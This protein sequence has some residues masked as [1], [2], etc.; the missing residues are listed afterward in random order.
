MGKVQP[1]LG[2]KERFELRPGVAGFPQWK[3]QDV[4]SNPGSIPIFKLRQLINGR[5]REDGI[6]S[7]GGQT[8]LNTSALDSSTACIQGLFDYQPATPS[9]LYMVLDGC[10]GISTTAGSSVAQYDWEQSPKFQRVIYNSTATNNYVLGVFDDK[11]HLG[12]DAELKSLQLIVYPYG[13]EALSASGTAQDTPIYTFTGFVVRHLRAFDAKL[14]VALD[15]GA[16]ASKIATWDGLSIRDDLTAINVPTGFGLWRE[17]LICGFGSATNLIKVRA[18][19]DSPGTWTNVAPGAGTVAMVSRGVSYKDKFYFP[20]GSTN[21]WSYDGTTLTAAHTIAGATT[22]CIATFNGLLYVGY[23]EGT[24]SARLAKFDGSTWTD[25]DKNFTTQLSGTSSIR[26][27][28]GYRGSLYA[29]C[30]RSSGVV[31]LRSPLA[32]TSG[33]WLIVPLPVTSGQ[34]QSADAYQFVLF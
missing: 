28:E 6:L 10:Y 16:G 12:L 11:M 21:V 19:G 14:F 15:A 1:E 17:T 7:R 29:G 5:F 30:I 8:K 25:V 32:T 20:D 27:L 24:P 4:D 3:G 31:M 9:K 13:T 22:R 33:T 23:D 34:P 18:V 26:T 2:K